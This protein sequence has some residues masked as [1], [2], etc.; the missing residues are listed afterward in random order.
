MY[1]IHIAC[2]IIPHLQNNFYYYRIHIM[3]H[4]Y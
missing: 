4:V 3:W 2:G 1:D